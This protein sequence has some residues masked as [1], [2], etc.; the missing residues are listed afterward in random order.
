MPTST[1]SLFALLF[2]GF[3]QPLF[4]QNVAIAYQNPDALYVCGTD[5]L[6]VTLQNT[7][8]TPVANLLVTLTF[9]TGI[10]YIPGT[11]AG[12]AE[13]DI[14]NLS[15]PKFSL[16]DIPVG[17]AQ[18]LSLP[19]KADCS[20]LDAINNG[21]QFSNTITASYAGGGQQLTTDFYKVETALLIITSVN[22]PAQSGMAGDVLT[23]TITV[24]NTRQGPVSAL[25]F[26]DE[27]QTG[28]S[29]NLAGVG[30]QNALMLFEADVPGSYFSAFGDGDQLFEYDEVVTFTEEITVTDCGIP[31]KTVASLI[32]IGWG[33]DW[34][35]CQSDSAEAL[36]TILPSDNNP[37][38]VFTPLYAP[39]QSYCGNEPAVQE[40]IVFNAGNAPAENPGVTLL[41]RDSTR[42]GLDIHSFQ[43]NTGAGWAPL[44]TGSGATTLLVPCSNDSFYRRVTVNL[45]TLAPGDSI[46]VRFDTYFCQYACRSD[47][48]GILVSYVYNKVCPQNIIIK[49]DFKL[50]PDDAVLELESKV[51]Y[52]I[53]V[54][55]EDNSVY[56]FD[57][58]VKS[59][60]LLTSDGYL[61]VTFKLPWGIF[62]ENSCIPMPDGQTPLS[63]TIDTAPDTLTTVNLVYQLPMSTDSV[64]GEIC[65]RNIC[66]SVSAYE[67]GIG[68]LPPS[69]ED[70]LIYPFDST[71]SACVQR[72]E[73]V[74]FLTT[75]PDPDD[76]C[77]ISNC[78]E[79][80]LVLD[81]GCE[82]DTTGNFRITG[83]DSWRVN[84]GLRDNDNNRNADS[85]DP[86][87]SPLVRLDRFLPGDTMRTL[88]RGVVQGS[89]LD[90]VSFRIFNESWQSDFGLD[91]GDAFEILTAKTGFSNADLLRFLDGSVTLKI[92]ATGQ[93]FT[94]PVGA[95]SAISD[96]HFIEVAEPNIRPEQVI[97]QLSSMFHQFTVDI[98]LLA[99]LGCVPA[100]MKLQPGD[101]VVFTGDFKFFQN[102]TPP[103]AVDPPLINFRNTACNTGSSI[104]WQLDRCLPPLLRQY[105]G[106]KERIIPPVFQ[107]Q[108]CENATELSPFRYAI[109]I[110]RENLFPYEVRRLAAIYDFQHTL[111]PGVSLIEAKLNFLQLQETVPVFS[112]QIMPGSI[113][114]DTLT[115]DFLP[116]FINPLDE[117]LSL[118][119]SF[120]LGPNCKFLA[121]KFAK[122]KVGTRYFSDDFRN[123]N[124]FMAEVVNP[125][126]YLEGLPGLELILQDTVVEVPDGELQLD[127]FLY[128][129]APFPAP[130]TWLSWET[131]GDFSNVELVLMPQQTPLPA[132]GNL[133]QLGE[134][135]TF[136]VFVLRLKGHVNSCDPIYLTIRYGWDCDPV[137]HP[138]G[139]TCGVFEKK[140]L[141][142]TADPELELVVIAQPDDV[143]M[144]APSDIFE[145]EIYNAAEGI[146]FDVLGSVKLPP[147]LSVVPNSSR[148]SYPAGSPFINLA[149]PVALPGNVW[150]WTPES[151]SAALATDGLRSIDDEPDNALRIRFRVQAACGFVANTR[152][153]YGAE[154]LQPCGALTNILRKPG[155]ALQLEGLGPSYDVTANLAYSNV[156]DGTDCGAASVLT[157]TITLDGAPNPGDSIYIL[158]PAGVSYDPGS[159]QPGQ[160]A[161]GG[162]PQIIGNVMQ[163]PFPANLPGNATLQFNFAVRYDN[164]AGCTD[165][166]IQ[167]Q[168]RERVAVFCPLINQNCAAYIATGEALL[169][170]KAKNADLVLQNFETAL[171]NNT[172][173]W[174]AEL[175]NEGIGAATD[176]LVQLFLDQ[177]GN[178]QVDPNEPM[179]ASL[180]PGQTIAPGGSLPLAGSLNLPPDALCQLIAFI[181]GVENCA[182]SDKIFPLNLNPV[183]TA[184]VSYC[185]VAAAPLGVD[186]IAGNTYTWLTPDGLSCTNCAH[187]VFTPGPEVQAG[188]AVTLILQEKTAN[189]TIEYHF[190]LQFGQSPDWNPADQFICRG[191]SA[192]LEPAPGG[193]YVWSGPGLT[194][195]TAP[196]QIVQPGQT[197]VYNVTITFAGGC[198]G[199]GQA[200][201][202]VSEGDSLDLGTIITCPGSPVNVFGTPTDQPGFYTQ[203]LQNVNG[204]DSVSFLRLVVFPTETFEVRPVCPG[205]SVVVFDS[206]FTQA[207]S[208]CRSYP[209]VVGCDSTHCISVE[210]L[211]EPVLPM[212]PDSFVVSAGG[213]VQLLAPAG[214][215]SYIW[216]PSEG[217]SCADC[218]DPLAS[219]DTSTIYL[220]TVADPN[221]CRAAATYRVLLCDFDQLS[222]PNAFTPNGDGVND[223]FRVVPSENIVQIQSLTIFNRWG[224]KVWQGSGA[225]AGWDG[226]IGGEPAA[227]DVYVWL[228]QGS[229]GT[230]L[231]EKKGDV[232]LLR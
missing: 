112:N 118:E 70:Y 208:L 185:D 163:L 115:L 7:A 53:G 160:N 47:N 231:R 60:Q 27:H 182:C 149:D 131:T 214:F 17:G 140:L 161:P 152:P 153:V 98:P 142:Q 95:A 85:F 111:P 55:L 19:L 218:P 179:V 189:C 35:V 167:L 59:K 20:I 192:K 13:A 188:D 54:C 175:L 141:L 156:Q 50:E 155:D 170:L 168:A 200:T 199:T 150:Q 110:A 210:V 122:T 217:L 11:I 183:V 224:Q 126:A 43:L 65:L 113:T 127:H 223:V 42:L 219:P 213:E 9:P 76:L 157:A 103:A 178:G 114:A 215:T 38:L 220:L 202:V 129:D 104:A 169:F 22:P 75:T 57:Y 204:C 28:L 12:A 201:V 198:T 29:I 46:R 146:A 226:M 48:T 159:Y 106:Y 72:V 99:T 172:L 4:S 174:I 133:F 64:F 132:T 81:C 225:N 73:A 69:G 26:S 181:P 56:T 41:S 82:D 197:S 21:V 45:P 37:L 205:D 193:S 139:N 92:A 101:S 3:F 120:K 52:D 100:D 88:T 61:R 108:A 154:A 32:R 211:P 87:N 164:A 191:A 94:C 176:P 151:A 24:R 187:A 128:N 203:N 143:P 107:M 158:L 49:G 230:D 206:V 33:C 67:P 66:Q 79:F 44:Q 105:S 123:P 147:G 212:V 194:N 124:P 58:W 39:P 15:A 180:S 125:F 102:F 6:K 137:S 227:S 25:H 71:C 97:D 162:P 136:D 51:Y 130:N 34:A 10:G 222:I 135:D 196:V 145:F 116:Y 229:C 184:P 83:F 144:C 14:T 36:V 89:N 171:N 134:L 8:A 93:Q 190:D 1:R 40:F 91:G 216:T 23:R 186:S 119:T 166:T 221:G 31:P 177:N 2:C 5:T 232:A 63:V 195:L 84:V 80:E 121:T 77:G 96:Q 62:W 109:R 30:G 165:Q 148:L 228:L 68:A 86:A 207:G 173:S 90:E 117:G 16:T 78:D 18:I 138:G 74:T 209:S